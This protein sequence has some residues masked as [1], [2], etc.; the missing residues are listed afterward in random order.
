[1]AVM[2]TP[3]VT[4]Q[5]KDS[6]STG[7]RG[8]RRSHRDRLGG[9]APRVVVMENLRERSH[10]LQ[11]RLVQERFEVGVLED[12]RG[13]LQWLSEGLSPRRGSDVELL[14]CNARM[15]GDAGLDVLSRWCAAH[16]HVPVLLVSAFTNAKLRAR[17]ARIPN[18]VVLDQDFSV[19]DVRAT[20][21][22]MVET[23]ITS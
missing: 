23:S 14:I 9:S 19:E 4:A 12:A 20:A 7:S 1:M 6:S 5:H 18:G 11:E 2:H 22:S 10:F 15:L 13:A 17:M 21:V 16:P 8:D 3:P